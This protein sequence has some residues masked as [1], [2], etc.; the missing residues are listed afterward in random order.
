VGTL[1]SATLSANFSARTVDTGVNLTVGPRAWTAN[2]V[3][4]P[5]IAGVGFE[6]SRLFGSGNLNVTCSGSGCNP[7]AGAISGRITGGF[8]GPTGEGAGIAYSLNSASV[9]TT[10]PPISAITQPVS[11]GGVAAFR[12]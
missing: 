9:F 12:R 10:S 6:A 11:V 2:A 7:S 4:V 3:N 5:I 8:S 1:N